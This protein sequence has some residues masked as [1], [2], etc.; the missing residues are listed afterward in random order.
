M[1]D[2]MTFRVNDIEKSKNFYTPVL[3]TL[4]YQVAFDEHFEGIRI[5]GFGKNGKIDTWF[6]NSKPAGGHTHIAWLASSKEEVDAFHK[7][8]I[9]AGGVDNGS[10]GPRPHYHANYYGAFVLD[11][12]N[13]N[14]EAVYRG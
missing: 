6:V 14:V 1:I 9:A 5:L 4:G 2:H 12:D 13:N 10:P 7:A 11:P 8:A 3:A